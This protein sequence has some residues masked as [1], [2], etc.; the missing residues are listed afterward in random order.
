MCITYFNRKTLYS[1]WSQYIHSD[2]NYGLWDDSTTIQQANTN[3]YSFMLNKTNIQKKHTLLNIGGNYNLLKLVHPIK[4]KNTK[5]DRILIVETTSFNIDNVLKEDGVVVIS[6]IVKNTD[7][8]SLY[9]DIISMF[10]GNPISQD[11][12]KTQ[13]TTTFSSIDFYD[14]TENTFNAYYNYLF[15]TFCKQKNLPQCVS[16]ILIYYFKSIP[17]Q[18]IIAVCKK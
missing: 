12:W 5:F 6:N 16:D 14:I 2:M 9:I 4:K 8:K 17:F 11:E 10:L 3:L 7:K 15:T 13:L 18:Y 1:L